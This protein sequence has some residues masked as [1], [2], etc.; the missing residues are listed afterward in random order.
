MVLSQNGQSEEVKLDDAKRWKW[1]AQKFWGGWSA[2]V[3]S[4]I[5]VHFCSR[6]PTFAGPSTLEL[7]ISDGISFSEV[8]VIDD[9]LN[10]SG[11]LSM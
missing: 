6:P 11:I 5:T 9:Q 8:M 2:K 10:L 7:L 1:T 4:Q 3:H